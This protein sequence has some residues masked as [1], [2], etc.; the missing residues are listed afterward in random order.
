MKAE[1]FK[2][3]IKCF[4][5]LFQSKIKNRKSKILLLLLPYRFHHLLK[6][7]VD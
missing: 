7:F 2:I 4:L 3:L 5:V 1:L 6:N